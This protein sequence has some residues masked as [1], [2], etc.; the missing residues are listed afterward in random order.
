LVLRLRQTWPGI[1]PALIA[2]AAGTLLGAAFF[3]LLPEATAGIGPSAAMPL[4]L[5]GVLLFF[6]LEKTLLWRHC[7]DP[8]CPVHATA[9]YLLLFG[10]GLHNLVD[11]LVIGTA[12]V[13]DLRLGVI[14]GVAVL[15]HEIPQEV[16]DFALLLESRLS[17]PRALAYNLLS[18]ATI[19]PGVVVGTLL[20][21]RVDVAAGGALAVAAGGF[22]YVALADLVPVLHARLDHEAMRD[23]IV[24]LLIGVALIWTVSWLGR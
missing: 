2:F 19:F 15:A 12:F 11:G 24:P 14:T 21:G 22:L 13:V 8:D 17:P 9:G 4:A 16:G 18:A 6:F 3:G 1:V 23:Q 20:A 10:D 7:H 5:L